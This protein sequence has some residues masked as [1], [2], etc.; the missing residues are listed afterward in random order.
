[1]ALLKEFVKPNGIKTTYHRVSQ[2]SLTAYDTDE[3]DSLFV[4][5]TSYLDEEKRNEG[6]EVETHHYHFTIEDGESTSANV[7][8]LAYTKLK[9]LPDWADAVDC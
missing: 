8:E 5:L 6:H 3:K 4:A 2:A 9:E 1:M 7:L